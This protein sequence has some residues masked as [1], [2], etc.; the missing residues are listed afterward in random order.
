VFEGGSREMSIC[1]K[2]VK[3]CKT[4]DKSCGK[5]GKSCGNGIISDIKLQM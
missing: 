4:N 1:T 5:N 2:F 3:S